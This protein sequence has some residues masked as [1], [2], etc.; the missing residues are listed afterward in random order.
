MVLPNHVGLIPDG[1]RRWAQRNGVDLYS[2]YLRGLDV[3]MDAVDYLSD[4][5]VGY[6][7]VFAMS[8]D[9]C[10]RRSRLEIEI[11]KKIS[12][13]AFER[14]LNHN[15]VKSGKARIVV[16]GKPQLVGNE[17]K[18]EAFRIMMKTRWH[19]PYTVTILYCYSGEYEIEAAEKGYTPSSILV[20]PRLDLVIRTGGYP[21]L[22]GFLPLRADYAELYA[23]DTLWP[24]LTR[25]EIDEALK[26]Y[27]MLPKN[28]GR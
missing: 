3:L 18:D 13:I 8:L 25:K 4:R 27:S 24:D 15:K 19:T 22:S 28:F 17:I 21:R 14:V 23:T 2:A 6:I 12:R 7:T 20:H 1:N 5:G 9:N 10:R 16:L 26:W 11:L